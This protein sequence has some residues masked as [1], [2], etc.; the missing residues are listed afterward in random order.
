LID[1]LK[2][3]LMRNLLICIA[4]SYL[5]YCKNNSNIIFTRADAI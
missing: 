2:E 5:S 4:Q 3:Q 1:F